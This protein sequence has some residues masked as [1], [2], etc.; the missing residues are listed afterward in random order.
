M[1]SG[2]YGPTEA[3]GFRPAAAGLNCAQGGG[4]AQGSTK[5]CRETEGKKE[6][7]RRVISVQFFAA[8]AQRHKE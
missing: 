5:E 8:K 1:D 2:R 4:V 7:G 3:V 6:V